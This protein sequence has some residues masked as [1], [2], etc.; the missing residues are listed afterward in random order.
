MQPRPRPPLFAPDPKSLCLCGSGLRFRHC[1][2]SRL[3]GTRNG[4]RWKKAADDKRWTETV[5]HLRADVTQ[6]TIWHLSHTAPAVARKPDL[7][8]GWL[9]NVDIEA[10]SDYVES[11]M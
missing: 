11:L 8:S 10:L 3:P 6:Y 1:C 7:R 2:S 5:R 4:E 9:M